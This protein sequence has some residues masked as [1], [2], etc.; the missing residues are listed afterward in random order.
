MVIYENNFQF[1]KVQDIIRHT[2]H[3]IDVL[4]KKLAQQNTIDNRESL[5]TE[6][7]TAKNILQK[8]EEKLLSLKKDNTKTFMIAVCLIFVIFLIFGL[9]LMI[10]NPH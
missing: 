7:E 1:Q 9:Y 8:N 10:F 2:Y 6:L 5:E 3:R 4:E